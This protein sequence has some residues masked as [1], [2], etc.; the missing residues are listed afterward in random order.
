MSRITVML[1]LVVLVLL[2]PG[3]DIFGGNDDEPFPGCTD[4][5]AL[6]FLPS[7]EINDGSCFYQGIV[8]FYTATNA[9]GLVDIYVNDQ[10]TGRLEGFWTTQPGSCGQPFTVTI[11]GL[12]NAARLK[13]T[14]VAE[15]G[16]VSGGEAFFVRGC[17]FIRV[18]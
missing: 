2:V 4:P 18:F 8:S 11:T 12:T 13:W 10:F 5:N 3:C 7:A 16:T 9:H 15:D 14:A 17:S 6:N 1:L